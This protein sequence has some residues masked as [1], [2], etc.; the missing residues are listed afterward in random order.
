[1]AGK[2]GPWSK[3]DRLFIRQNYAKLSPEKIGEHLNRDP[4]AI[5]KYLE[6]QAM[7]TAYGIETEK[8]LDIRQTRHW[9]ILVSQFSETELDICVYHWDAILEQFNENIQHTEE[10]QV[11]DVIKIEVLSNRVLTAE[12]QQEKAIEELQ[13]AIRAER[14]KPIAERNSEYILNMEKQVANLYAAIETISR[15]YRDLLKQKNAML[16]KLKATRD[17]RIQSLENKHESIINWFRELENNPTLR[18]KLGLEMEKSRLAAKEEYM[19]LSDWYTYADGMVDQ[20]ILCA[21]TV[22][23]DHT[24]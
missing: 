7:L 19:R 12:K 23:D 4:E 3:E 20:P 18:K 8:Y 21:E 5:K 17:H 10:I 22:K 9:P 11:I 24:L 1:M 15:E 2:R 14:K 13:T 16:D 6:Q